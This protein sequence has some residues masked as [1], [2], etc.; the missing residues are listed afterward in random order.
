MSIDYEEMRRLGVTPITLPQSVFLSR[1][2]AAAG[3]A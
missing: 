1:Q 2:V 3:T